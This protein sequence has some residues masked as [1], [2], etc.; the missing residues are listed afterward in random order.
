LS[1]DNLKK[2]LPEIF[3]MSHRKLII[4]LSFCEYGAGR[5]IL[6]ALRDNNI[7]NAA[8]VVTRLFAKHVGLRRFSIM[9]NVAIDALRK[10]S[11]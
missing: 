11:D 10:L 1:W 9:E 6:G 3:E 4:F 8:V 7:E 2:K 5:K